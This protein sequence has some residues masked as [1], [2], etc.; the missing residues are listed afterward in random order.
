MRQEACR[1]K[2][3]RRNVAV[4]WIEDVKRMFEHRFS[5]LPYPERVTELRDQG[6]PVFFYKYHSLHSNNP[7]NP[8]EKWDH[9]RDYLIN[10]RFFLSSAANF[11]D[12]FDMKGRIVSKMPKEKKKYAM[13][14]KIENEYRN[15]TP[16][17]RERMVA[18]MFADPQLLEEHIQ[19]TLGQTV[20]QFG[21]SCLSTDP[22]NIL[23]WSHYANHHR[24][25]A[26]QFNQARHIQSF[27]SLQEVEYSNVYPELDYFDRKN[28]KQYERLLRRKHCGWAYEN[29]WRFLIAG[30]ANKYLPFDQKTLT[31]VILGCPN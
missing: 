21:V 10:S 24:G 12:P 7:K 20:K 31:A 19:L 30:S 15:F 8:D 6:F 27:R 4:A 5:Q 14:K 28:I 13:R 23:M 25:I 16:D 11:N 22:C 26:F 29:E 1:K 18:Y 2:P 17:Q 9:A 3:A